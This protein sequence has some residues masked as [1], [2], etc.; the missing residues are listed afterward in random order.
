MPNKGLAS[1]SHFGSG[2]KVGKEKK[3][4]GIR[5]KQWST[6]DTW[7]GVTVSLTWTSRLKLTVA[8]NYGSECFRVNGTLVERME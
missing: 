5:Y 4:N 7:R 3:R 2:P 1:L 8:Q 6:F